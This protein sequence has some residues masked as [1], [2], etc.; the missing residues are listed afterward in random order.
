MPWGGAWMLPFLNC[1]KYHEGI[2]GIP[3]GG[4][5]SML[6]VFLRYN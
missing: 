4:V 2:V 6:F 3:K 1:F 5:L